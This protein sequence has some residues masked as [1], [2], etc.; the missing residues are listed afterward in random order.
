MKGKFKIIVVL[1]ALLIFI[2]LGYIILKPSISV[3]SNL[4]EEKCDSLGDDCWH[5]LAHQTFNKTYCFNIRDNE[6]KEH[7]LEHMPDVNK[8]NK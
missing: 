7:C 6:T 8:N 5:S 3:Y 4:S 1:S 2:I